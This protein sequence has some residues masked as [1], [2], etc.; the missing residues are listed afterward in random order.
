MSLSAAIRLMKRIRE[1]AVCYDDLS[2]EEKVIADCLIQGGFAY[3][4]EDRRL[5]LTVY[6]AE[7]V[8]LDEELEQLEKKENLDDIAKDLIAE[9]SQYIDSGDYSSA[10]FRLFELYYVIDALMYK[11]G[12]LIV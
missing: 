12:R 9:I 2:I 10:L 11:Q 3:L 4:T 7:I 1:E 5:K 8:A 6:G